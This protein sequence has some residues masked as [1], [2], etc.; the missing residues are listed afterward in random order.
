MRL[1]DRAIL[2]ISS[3]GFV[4]KIPFAP[5]T[6]G[7]VLGLPICYCLAFVKV[8][9]AILL[10]LLFVAFSIWIADK[11]EKLLRSKD[12]GYI[13][14]DEIA[15]LLVTFLGIPFNLLNG[16]AGFLIFRIMDILK[17]FPA[18][19]LEKKLPGGVGVVMDDVAAGLYS[20]LLLRV[21]VVFII[22]WN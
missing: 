6:F 16:V 12:P 18:R 19:M 4:G 14:I 1:R 2:F 17:P 22:P 3:G 5:G 13:V 21:L 9:I 8:R 20:N 15:G 7:S 10:T 11:A